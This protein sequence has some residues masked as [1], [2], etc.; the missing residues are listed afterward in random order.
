[1]KPGEKIIQIIPAD[2]WYAV[3]ENGSGGARIKS[4]IALW[5]LVNHVSG[6]CWVTGFV[7]PDYIACCEDNENFVGYEYVGQ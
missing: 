1:M 3:Y 4:R 2:G 5:A 7:G 6:D